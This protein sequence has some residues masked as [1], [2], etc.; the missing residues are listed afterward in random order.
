MA[1]STND[2]FEFVHKFSYRDY[3]GP[4]TGRLS[5]IYSLATFEMI[6][7]WRKSTIGKVI[8][9][10]T[11]FLNV[12]V[13]VITVPFLN[14]TNSQTIKSFGIDKTQ[15]VHLIVARFVS[16][17]LSLFEN[18]IEPSKTIV[19]PFRFPIGFL[20]IGLLAIAGSGFFADDKQGKVIELYL[21]RMR[22]ED[23]A[24]GKILGMFLY[25]N[26]FITL[27]MFVISA[28]FVQGMGQNQFDYLVVYLGIISVG[29]LI[30]LIFTVFTLLLSS[31]V[32]K[33][34]Y[35]SLSFFIGYILFDSLSRG[36]YRTDPSNQFLLLV[37]PT[38]VISILV[39]IFIGEFS[40]GVYNDTTKKITP[41]ILNNG[42]GVESWYVLVLV[43]AVLLIG[44]LLLLFKI[45]R[46]TTNEL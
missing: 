17:Y 23:Y 36:F 22:R 10:L 6:N 7:T 5:R 39:Y 33:R 9:G 35:A 21:S 1:E 29:A 45:H 15:Y 32:E 2:N 31:L 11:L 12:F 18:A 4:R 44:L 41:L 28:W 46:M 40:L 3:H 30:S 14:L 25:C 24:I 13:A 27:P 8:L 37:V 43:F 42:T 19:V 20:I 26:M 38:Y 34:A 16:D